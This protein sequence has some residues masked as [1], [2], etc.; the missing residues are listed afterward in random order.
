MTAT[1]APPEPGGASPV[2]RASGA[3]VARWLGA[4]RKHWILLVLVLAGAVLRL[5]AILAYQPALLFVD[6]FSYLGNVEH[7][8]P[9]GLRP[10][11]YELILNV[12]LPFG[13]LRFVTVVQ[14]LLG[15]GIAV[16]GYGLLLR[17]GARRPLAA[18]A[19]VPLLFDAYQVQIEHNIMS[20]VWFQA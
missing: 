19:T 17:H 2:P 15:L 5:L 3:R 14:H 9:D 18:L 6:S 8:R 10:I 20:D 11:G 13:D 7:L 4:M 16:A 1:L 12:L